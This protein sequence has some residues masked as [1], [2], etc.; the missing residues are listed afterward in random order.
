MKGRLGGKPTER[1]E[2]LFF[3]IR[4]DKGIARRIGSF[5]VIIGAT[6]SFESVLKRR[7]D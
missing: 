5:E 3:E 7:K 1:R 6:I 2:G 4:R